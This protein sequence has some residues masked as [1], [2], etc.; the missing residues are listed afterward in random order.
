MQSR[1]QGVKMRVESIKLSWFRGAGESVCLSPRSKSIVIYGA[2]G[3]GKSSFADAF[4]Y[5]VSKGKIDHL[6]HEYS[7]LHQRHGLRNTHA[8]EGALSKITLYG[9][10]GFNVKP[11][12]RQPRHANE[13]A[14]SYGS[15]T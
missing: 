4:E 13:N 2:N 15:Q 1:V 5:M 14:E 11:A 7:G 3:A 12:Q 9:S 8:P 6:A 10:S